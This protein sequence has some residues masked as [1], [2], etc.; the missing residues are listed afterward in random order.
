MMSVCQHYEYDYLSN[1]LLHYISRTSIKGF[2]S[3]FILPSISV[4]YV[5]RWRKH[6]P[7]EHLVFLNIQIKYYYCLIPSSLPTIQKVTFWYN[8]NVTERIFHEVNNPRGENSAP[9]IFCKAKISNCEISARQSL[10]RRN[11]QWV[12]YWLQNFQRRNYCVCIW[13][14]YTLLNFY[15]CVC[16]DFVE[17]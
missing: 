1:F 2:K 14:A 9:Q 10:R 3:S 11:Y 8:E 17:L 16:S 7:V 4:Y 12:N 5:V 15:P 6:R 13:Y